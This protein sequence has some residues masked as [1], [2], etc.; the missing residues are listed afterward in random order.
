M[1]K[2][3]HYK[4]PAIIALTIAGSAITTHQA[5]AQSNSETSE[6]TNTT[7]NVNQNQQPTGNQTAQNQQATQDTAKTIAGTQQ[8]KDPTQIQP[9]ENDENLSYDSKLDQLNN[10]AEPSNEANAQPTADAQNNTTD[11]PVNVTQQDTEQTN[12]QA[13]NTQVTEQQ[14]LAEQQAQAAQQQEQA[15]KQQTQE[16]QQAVQK[17][18]VSEQNKASQPEAQTSVNQ[19]TPQKVEQPK[20]TTYAARSTE[21]VTTFRSVQQPTQTAARSVQQPTQT[22]TR[23]AQTTQ[24]AT[25]SAQPAQTTY[26]APKPSLPKYKPTVKSSI[27][28]YIRQQNY[29]V[30]TYEQD[31]SSYI[32]KYNYRYGKPEGIVI[33]DTANENSTLNNEVAYMKN[34]WQN[35]FVHGFVDGNRIV[36][37]A[38]TDYLAWGAGPVANERYIHMELV[39]THDKDSFARQM[40]NIADYAATNLQ[41]YGLKP[42]SAEYD[43]RGTVWTHRAVS[44]FLGGTDHVDPHGYLQSRGYNYDALYDL[45]N[46]KYLIKEGVVAPWGTASNTT[47]Q[48]TQPTQPTTKPTTKPSTNTSQLKLIPVDS[49]G[50]LNNTNNGLYKTVYDKAGVQNSNLNNQTYR[51]TK[52]ALLG[53][54]SFYLIS[55][56]NKGTNYGW[57]QT[58][59]ITYKVGHPVTTNTKTYG[60]QSGTKLYSTPWG[61]DKQAV[62]TVSGTGAQAFKAS[63]QTEVSPTQFVYGTVN[64]KSGWVDIAKLSNYTAPKTTVNKPTTQVKGVSTTTPSKTTTTKKAVKPATKPA[65]KTTTKTAVKPTAKPVAKTTTKTAV[66]PAAT[67]TKKVV[68]PATKPTTAV[69]TTKTA[70]KPA[71]KKVVNTV[72]SVAKT[73]AQKVQPTAKAATTTK[74][75]SK[76]ATTKAATQTTKAP[77]NKTITVNKLGQY[78]S[79]NYGLRASVYD[80]KGAKAAK[81]LGYTYNITRERNQDGTLYYLL[82]N[83][84]LTTPLGWVNAKDVRVADKGLVTPTSQQYS[85]N[86]KSNGLYTTPW[87]TAKQLID[88][89][90]KQNGTFKAIKRTL[91][92]K[93]PYVYGTVNGKTGWVAEKTL[94]PKTTA[95]AATTSAQKQQPAVKYNHDYIVTSNKG[96]YYK[97]PN[98]QVLGS[99]KDQ[100]GNIITVFERQVVNGVTWYHGVLANGQTAWVKAA[101]VRNT[102]TRTNV[103]DYSFDQAV[104]KQMNLPWSPKVQHVPGQWDDASEDEVRTAM[105]PR[106]ITEDATQK[107]QFLRLDKAQALSAS[108]V[109]KLLEGKGILEGQGAAF[110]QAAKTYDINEIYLISHALLET[111]NGT[112]ALANGGYVNNANKVVTNEPKK[113]YNMFGIGAIDTDAVRGGFKTAAHYGW[114]TVEK[115]IIGGAKFITSDYLDRG[116]NTLYRMRWNPSEPATHQYATD[117]NWASHNATRMKQM[118]DKIGETGKYFDTDIYRV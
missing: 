23:S 80:K 115:A 72:K 87:G 75:V 116:Q 71:A 59:D 93:T 9:K 111:G 109:N 13:Q 69:K 89:L 7:S 34:N 94:T 82:Q 37:T 35:A 20:A 81:F 42:D 44:N 8:Y 52:K 17:Q 104:A 73:T 2:K 39:H 51:L 25:R 74:A 90:T 46:E 57:V 110:T 98:G 41:Y 97:T 95:K 56:Y 54:K 14:K 85:V 65:A 33:H 102:L 45:I 28:D 78:V 67:T 29:K 92:N 50:R 38:N 49:L 15:N 30:P 79:D 86:T 27:N 36:E 5:Y 100:F 101:D 106:T 76:P 88:P 112:S 16:A 6:P 96:Y 31:Y 3:F 55:D 64:G 68:K 60:V 63:K 4:T 117:I 48:P 40:N 114:D 1:S 12:A 19:T 91:V 66:K 77:L 113:Y 84:G 107:Y 21:P 22:A 83:I 99:L 58:G 43:G 70:V 105:D 53:D 118:Y 61:T 26:S 108:S 62:A 24:T 47:T 10:Q 32:P 18:V 11:Q 103:S